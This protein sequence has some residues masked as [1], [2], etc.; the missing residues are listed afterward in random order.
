MI[1]LVAL[2][3]HTVCWIIR[4]NVMK[5]LD[6]T[7]VA[8]MMPCSAVITGIL[9]ILLGMDT[10]TPTLFG[11][12]VLMF[13]ASALSGLG[14]ARIKKTKNKEYLAAKEKSQTAI[15]QTT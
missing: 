6:A 5:H 7:V 9:S 15:P 10:L 13:S 8:V 3:S 14:D 2:L 12:A 11:G 1:V 4:T